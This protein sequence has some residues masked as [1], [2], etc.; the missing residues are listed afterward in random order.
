[1]IDTTR[2]RGEGETERRGG[3]EGELVAEGVASA[4]VGLADLQGEGEGREVMVVCVSVIIGRK[5]WLFVVTGER[6]RKEVGEGLFLGEDVP[7]SERREGK[8]KGEEG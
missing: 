5:L 3:G 2:G 4:R 7:E 6:D 1:M 8:A